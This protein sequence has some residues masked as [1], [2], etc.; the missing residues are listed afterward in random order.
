MFLEKKSATLELPALPNVKILK[1]FFM[2]GS[3][4]KVNQQANQ[5][6]TID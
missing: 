5:R 1:A 6:I 3:P 2:N 4:V